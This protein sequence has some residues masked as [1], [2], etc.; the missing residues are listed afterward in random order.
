MQKELVSVVIPTFNSA[1]YL[2]E[3]IESALSQTHKN[4]EVVVVSDGCTDSTPALMS[5]YADRYKNVKYI[6]RKENRGISYTRNEGVRNA[7]GLYIAVSDADDVM[8]PERVEKSLKALKKAKVDVVYTSYM[9]ADEHGKVLGGQDCCPSVTKENVL[10][11]NSAPHVTI[12]AKKECFTENGY[13]DW[14]KVNDDFILLCKWYLAGYQFAP[15]HEPLMLVRY[16]SGSTSATRDKEIKAVHKRGE[17]LLK[18]V[19]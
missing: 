8:H 4:I 16:H 2:A 11:N 15:I 9:Q 6:Y 3:S 18:D 1:V 19:K 13:E 12:L 10:A 5:Y 7:S 17:G 14:A